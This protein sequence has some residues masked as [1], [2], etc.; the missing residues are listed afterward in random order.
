MDP[1]LFYYLFNEYRDIYSEIA[2]W[3]LEEFMLNIVLILSG[4]RWGYLPEINSSN[5]IQFKQIKS[6][7]IMMFP[8]LVFRPYAYANSYIIHLSENTDLIDDIFNHQDIHKAVGVVL[9]FSCVG[10]DWSNERIDRYVVN[11]VAKHPDREQN[12]IITFMCPVATFTNMDK[13]QA[14]DLA[15][16]SNIALQPYGY[17][18]TLKV[19]LIRT[20]NTRRYPTNI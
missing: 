10:T 9:G 3:R 8:N 14:F 12:Y 18:I 7:L 15:T 11:I 2:F 1:I 20:N 19:E 13:V 16:R 4:V 17:E 5:P 6:N